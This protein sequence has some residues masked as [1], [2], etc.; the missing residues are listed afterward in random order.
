MGL[1]RYHAHLIRKSLVIKLCHVSLTHR[2][3]QY[4]KALFR[5]SLV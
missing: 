3:F 4:F 1:Q 2:I 5:L